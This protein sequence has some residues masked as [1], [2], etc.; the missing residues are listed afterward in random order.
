[1]AHELGA[2]AFFRRGGIFVFKSLAEILAVESVETFSY[3]NPSAGFPIVSYSSPNDGG[4]TEDMALRRYVGWGITSGPIRGRAPAAA[5]APEEF[6]SGGSEATMDALIQI[7]IVAIDFIASGHGAITS[8]VPVDL[9]MH[10]LR[11]DSPLDESVPP[12]VV[13][14]VVAHHYQSQKYAIRVR[15]VLPL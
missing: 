5:F 2:V 14:G 15:G 7:P 9:R 11:T 6:S 12:K 8:G 13:V 10:T 3:R 1:M 4:L